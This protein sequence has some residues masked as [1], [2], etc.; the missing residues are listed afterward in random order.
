MFCCEECRKDHELKNHN[1][2]SEC[3]ICIRG[4]ILLK[5]PSESLLQHI[6]ENHWPLHCIHCERIFDTVNDIFIHNKCP[7]S[8]LIEVDNDNNNT[9]PTSER[10]FACITT[11]GQSC[12]PTS[13]PV[14][15]RENENE[16]LQKM[17]E[18]ITP[19]DV[20]QK[21]EI[22]N[23]S[24]FTPSN[25]SEKRNDQYTKRRVTFSNTVEEITDNE[26]IQPEKTNEPLTPSSQQSLYITAEMKT[27]TLSSINETDEK[28]F[29]EGAILQL[30]M[31]ED[32]TLWETAIND[33]EEVYTMDKMVTKDETVEEHCITYWPIASDESESS[34][35]NQTNGL[36]NSMTNIFK[37]VIQSISTSQEGELNK[38]HMFYLFHLLFFF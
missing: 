33:F 34:I 25:C 27:P 31:A 7:K 2:H 14:A 9:P 21:K 11:A 36:W 1:V 30:S 35:S 23:K 10:N 38:I 32:E 19:V 15:P 29:N 13:T 26:N 28:D 16:F 12:V 8:M 24:V 22:E 17:T 37:N 4:K 3:D 5:D 6:R 18:T 20:L